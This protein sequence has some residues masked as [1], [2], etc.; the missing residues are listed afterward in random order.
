MENAR[1]C[2]QCG[3]SMPKPEDA[4]VLAHRLQESLGSNFEVV[5]EIGRGGFALVYLVRALESR[6]LLAVKVMRG[7]LMSSAEATERFR[8][9]IQYASRLNHPNILSVDFAGEDTGLLYYA[10]PRVKGNTLAKHLERK[11]SASIDEARRIL[12]DL[13]RGLGYAH[14][15]GVIHRDV[16]PSNV[17]LD[18][19]G[20]AVIMD[21]GIAKALSP[22]GRSLTIS[23]EIIGSPRYMSPEQA[24][25]SKDI[26]RR[27]DI[28][29][30]GVVGFRMLAG[31]VPFDGKTAQAILYQHSIAERPDLRSV[32][33][34]VPES[35]HTPLTD[36]LEPGAEPEP[37]EAVSTDE[38]APS[39]EAIDS[40]GAVD[41]LEP[42]EVSASIFTPQEQK[43]VTVFDLRKGLAYALENARDFQSAKE[44]LYLAALDL[45]LERHL[46][47]PQFVASV[48]A[49]YDNFDDGSE[50]DSAMSTVSE[51]SVSQQLPFGGEVTAR[52]IHA[53]VREVGD[54]VGKGESGR[55]VL[56]ARIPL[57]RGAGRVAYESRYSSEREMVYAVRRFERFRRSFV[58]DVAGNYFNLQ[59]Q[60]ASVAN[61]YK[62]Y[63]SQQR[64]SEKADF[65]PGLARIHIFQA[66][67]AKSSFC[68]A[69]A[70]LGGSVPS[71]IF[72]KT[73]IA[74]AGRFS[75]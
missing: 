28:Y 15:Q 19:A 68:R 12:G 41:R 49:D 67:R 39:A 55:V 33:P 31:R 26:D 30:W 10:M 64:E 65:M 69:A 17:M 47:T 71:G 23:G 14:D 54:L 45:T 2:S 4:R 1:F 72:A 32:R 13:A 57:L 50:L 75:T 51:V 18:R 20:T 6:K 62:S 11:G 44:D 58:V 53:L 52:I 74:V 27:A 37:E 29:S 70:S 73:E 24:S 5:G 48:Q 9:E 3:K 35:F 56:D 21:F 38:N 40:S 7:E 22:D 43:N 60:K 66:S 36:Q 16:K 61:I 46:W 59:Q 8:R 34:D 25:G 42:R 63:L